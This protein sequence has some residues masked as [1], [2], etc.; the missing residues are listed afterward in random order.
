MPDYSLCENTPNTKS[1]PRYN[2]FLSFASIHNFPFCVCYA[3]TTAHSTLC[4]IEL[5]VCHFCSGWM[6]KIQ[7]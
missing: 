4:I 1:H 5:L 7:K 3:P 6:E 2:I